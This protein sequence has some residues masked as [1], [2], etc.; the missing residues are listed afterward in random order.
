MHICEFGCGKE[1][2][3]QFKSSGKWCCSKNANS[4][5]GK[6]NTDR[7]KKRGKNPWIGKKHPRA[8]LGCIP[9]N[10]GKTLEELYGNVKA[11]E[12]RKQMSESKIGCKTWHKIDKETVERIKKEAS[13]RAYTRHAQGWQGAIGRCKKI[14]YTSPIAG[15]VMLDGGW[16]LL[17]AQYFDKHG[18]DWRRNKKRFKY[19]YNNKERFYTPDFF[20]VKENSFIEVKGYETDL[21]REKWRQFP[22][23]L[24]VWKKEKIKELRKIMETWVSG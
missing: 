7:E 4:C 21:D 9:P 1:A 6:K 13:E 17:V 14:K 2:I 11:E 15:E 24:E 22:E 20:L 10:K 5:E 8:R 19:V 12:I 16:E 23:K 3:H 18:I